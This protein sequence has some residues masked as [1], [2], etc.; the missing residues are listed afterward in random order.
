MGEEECNRWLETLQKDIAEEKD[1]ETL[2][3][4]VENLKSCLA[5]IRK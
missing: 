3:Y 1:K 5:K 2:N 4:D